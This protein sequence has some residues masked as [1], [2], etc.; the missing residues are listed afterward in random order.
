MNH[1][2]VNK[3]GKVVNVI[4][5]VGHEWIPPSD[6]LVIRTDVAGIGD[7]YDHT[8]GV[9]AKITGHK[10]HRDTKYQDF[11]NSKGLL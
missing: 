10:V 7:S 6:H 8:T 4:W 3:E 5:W 2:L 1:A 9:F 11:V